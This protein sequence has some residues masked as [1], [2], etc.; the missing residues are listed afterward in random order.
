MS[1]RDTSK[2]A[3]KEI[4]ENNTAGKQSEV[5][6]NVIK[7]M[8]I[9]EGTSLSLREIQAITSY[10]INAVSGRVNGLKKEG[11]VREDEK[12]KCKVTGRLITAVRPYTMQEQVNKVL[13]SKSTYS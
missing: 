5:I 12:R 4:N 13:S 11:L 9:N 7:D 2:I 10:D 6:F 1:V 8:F 3:Y